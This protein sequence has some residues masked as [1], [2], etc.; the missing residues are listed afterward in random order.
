MGSD[1]RLMLL[2]K[3]DFLLK[4]FKPQQ[5]VDIITSPS[6]P[7]VR[8]RF[9]SFKSLLWHIFSQLLGLQGL[10][11]PRRNLGF[12]GFSFVW[13]FFTAIFHLHPSE[14]LCP[15]WLDFSL[16]S[17]ATQRASRCAMLRWH[18]LSKQGEKFPHKVLP[19]FEPRTL[20][21]CQLPHCATYWAMGMRLTNI[22]LFTKTTFWEGCY[23]QCSR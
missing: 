23:N 18:S 20:L 19:G 1:N 16:L 10:P 3:S 17:W 8:G 15:L 5:G 7:G 4:V 22:T 9:G 6:P 14:G 11:H 2:T 13:L 21:L 12:C